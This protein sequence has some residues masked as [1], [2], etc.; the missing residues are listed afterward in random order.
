MVASDRREIF[1]AYNKAIQADSHEEGPDPLSEPTT[2]APH[3]ADSQM[4]CSINF[5]MN[6]KKWQEY[7][8]HDVNGNGQGG[9]KHVE[10]NTLHFEKILLKHT[11]LPGL[12]EVTLSAITETGQSE[13]LT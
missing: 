7:Y 10:I 12:P 6:A 13:S 4:S 3:R 2:L 8:S 9:H 1:G 11:S 5:E